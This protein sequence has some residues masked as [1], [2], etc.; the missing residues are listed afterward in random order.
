MVVEGLSN[1][2]IAGRLYLSESTIKQH[3]RAVVYMGDKP[4]RPIEFLVRRLVGTPESLLWN[5]RQFLASLW[6]LTTSLTLCR[7]VPVACDP[8]YPGLV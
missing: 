3:L 2:E 4:G 8:I 1:A 6:P 5:L 7:F